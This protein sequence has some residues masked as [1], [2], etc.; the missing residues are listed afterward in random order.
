LEVGTDGIIGIIGKAI[1]ITN[2]DKEEV[3][4]DLLL[5]E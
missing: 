5:G 1:A 3:K 4:K 2:Q